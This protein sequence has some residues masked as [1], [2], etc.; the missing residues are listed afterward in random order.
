MKTVIKSDVD[1]I[2]IEYVPNLFTKEKANKYLKIFE[3]EIE[4]NSD[5]ESM[6]MIHGKKMKIPRKQVAY[7]KPGTYYKFSGIKVM[8]KSWDNL[9]NDIVCRCMH[10][11]RRKVEKATGLKFNFCLINRYEDGD[12]CIGYH[13]DDEK[14]LGATP[15]IAGISLGA[16]RDILFKKDTLP[17]DLDGVQKIKLENGSLVTFLYPTNQHWKHSI[18]RRAKVKK[19]RVSLTFRY[20]EF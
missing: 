7:G 19:P 12:Q 1:K 13:K 14:Q 5:E 9:E 2:H 15:S 18:P 6:I 3:K 4:Y 10:N 11:I 20:M 16:E 8:A 17:T